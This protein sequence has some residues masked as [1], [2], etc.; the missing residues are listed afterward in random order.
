MPY[1]LRREAGAFSVVA[2]PDLCQNNVAKL[3]V[4]AR[5]VLSLISN[6]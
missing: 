3:S 5:T 6:V 4:F 1:R 2:F